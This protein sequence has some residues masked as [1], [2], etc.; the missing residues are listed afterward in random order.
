MT[1]NVADM[2]REIGRSRA[3]LERLMELAERAVQPGSNDRDLY[4]LETCLKAY[5]ADPIPQF[6]SIPKEGRQ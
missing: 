1:L 6:D 5:K 2:A 3:R 4:L